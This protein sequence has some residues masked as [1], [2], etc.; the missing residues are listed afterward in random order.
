[1]EKLMGNPTVEADLRDMQATSPLYRYQELRVPVM[2]VHGHD[3]ARVDYEH[4]RRLVRMLNLAGRTPVLMT[5][6]NEGHGIEDIDNLEA[7]W[8]GI[9]GFLQQHLG[10]SIAVAAPAAPGEGTASEAH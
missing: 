8:T 1:M 5:F 3:D 7:A 2:L 9:A 4:T 10:P 6:E